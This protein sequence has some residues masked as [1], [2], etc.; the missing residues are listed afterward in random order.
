[1]KGQAIIAAG[2]LL[3]SASVFG[4]D[5]QN[6]MSDRAGVNAVASANLSA[7]GT[8]VGSSCQ[9]G[10]QTAVSTSWSGMHGST[11]SSS[12]SYGSSTSSFSTTATGGSW[13]NVQFGGSGNSYYRNSA[14]TSNNGGL[15]IGIGADVNVH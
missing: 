6:R 14:T 7:S 1:M 4:C 15:N 10:N 9:N 3:I 12:T 13:S 11:A 2:V 8:S 5:G